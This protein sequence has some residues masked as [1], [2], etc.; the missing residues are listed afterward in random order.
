MK[1]L[2]LLYSGGMDSYIGWEWLDRPATLYVDLG[3]KYREKELIAIQDTIPDTK[4]IKN[5]VIGNYEKEDAE[6]P[7]RNLLLAIYAALEGA[8]NIAVIV[9][10]DEMSIPDRSDMFFDATSDLLSFLNGKEI[11][12]FSPFVS[13]DKTDMVEWYVHRDLPIQPLLDTVGCYS[14]VDGH[15][16]NCSAC[17]RRF[18]AFK[19]NDLDPGYTLT[20]EIK[21]IYRKS[22][23]S[24]SEDRQERMRRWL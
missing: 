19:N 2:I 20:E 11:E 1:N 4:I 21:T 18:I 8:N 23:S 15:C 12:V 3:H 9:Q 24:Y 14:D 16:G 6:I 5:H 22:L 7:N 10:K 17:L 13:M